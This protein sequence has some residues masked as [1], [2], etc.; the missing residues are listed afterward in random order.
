M[1]LLYKPLM[2]VFFIVVVSIPLL[3]PFLNKGF[4][5]TDDGDWMIIRFSAFHQTLRDGEFP[6]RF[7]GRLNQEYGYP[8]SN[9]LYPGFMYLAEPVHI[10]GFSFVDSIKIIL[11]LSIILSG[12]FT[13]LWLR[14]FFDEISAAVGASFYVY[15]PYHLY[16]LYKRGSVGEV[17]ALAIIPFILWQ[18]E[19]KSIFW[20]AIGI[21][22]L[23]LA[24]N[25][26][27]VLFLI[28]LSCY[29]LLNIFVSKKKKEIFSYFWM[30]LFGLGISSFFWLPALVE[31]PYTVFSKTVVSDWR[32]YFAP[33]AL[34]GYSTIVVLVITAVNLAAKNI[35]IAKHRL[36]FLIFVICLIMLFFATVVSTALWTVLPVGFIQFPFRLL[37]IVI[38][39]IAFLAACNISL[40]KG[41]KKY[42]FSVGLLVILLFSAM[43]FIKADFSDKG[44]GYYSTNLAT[45]TVQDEYMPLWVKEKPVQRFERKVE[46]IKGQGTINNIIYNSKKVSFTVDSKNESKVQINTI[47]WPGWKAFVN[48]REVDIS[49]NNPKGLI[50]ITLPSGAHQVEVSFGETPLR[51]VSDIIAFG[52][53]LVLLFVVLKSKIKVVH[54]K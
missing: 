51:W 45:T 35:V 38:V 34:I 29:M 20:S 47:Y 33:L 28:F 9:F 2:L 48:K 39:C 14:R 10:I 49:Y 52:S 41:N 32:G 22:L 54:K 12:F 1:K 23:L 8:V 16:D 3:V 37:S 27:A 19:R 13:Y 26:L 46:L 11:A 53:F 44:E 40:L 50:M 25:T 21:G 6:V 7:L 31:L 43:P 17:L 18:V 30:F 5:T 15:T 24:H 4:F 42:F 36:T